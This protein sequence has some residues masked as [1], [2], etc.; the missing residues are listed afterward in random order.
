MVL[1]DADVDSCNASVRGVLDEDDEDEDA[2]ELAQLCACFHSCSSH[3][4][5][6]SY[7]MIAAVP[8]DL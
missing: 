6:F 2:D 5:K 4:E 7:G 1:T 3:S 8:F